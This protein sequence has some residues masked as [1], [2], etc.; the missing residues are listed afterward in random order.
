MKERSAARKDA[1]RKWAARAGTLSAA[2]GA[3][4][5]LAQAAGSKHPFLAPV[6]V[7]LCMQTTIWHS[8]QFS[9]R[10]MGGTVLGVGLTWLAVKALPLNGWTVALALLLVL[11]ISLIIERS[12]L[13][14]RETALSVVLVFELQ[15]VSGHYAI[16]RVRETAIG[17]AVALLVIA[18]VFPPNETRAAERALDGLADRVGRAFGRLSVW[19]GGGCPP[20][21]A[22]ALST[23]VGT[24]RQDWQKAAQ[25]MKLADD[26]L[27]L[28][29]YRRKSDRRQRENA[30]ALEKLRLGIAYLEHAQWRLQHAEAQIPMD[31]SEKAAWASQFRKLGGC[32]GR[33]LVG[34]PP[35]E[36]EASLHRREE[37][38]V[39][40]TALTLDTRELLER[41]K[42]I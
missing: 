33:S 1:I 15:R 40:L 37:T 17:I 22:F 24:L 5:A 6:A 21:D 2:S 30:Y 16:D 35:L 8:I 41:L 10:R 39:Y 31:E 19:T 14:M 9:Y 7:I 29:P 12:E 3:A 11:G 32:W 18:F 28:H 36:P 42:R 34:A 38:P 4:W 26:S 27:R 13:W 23:E 25:S 20:A